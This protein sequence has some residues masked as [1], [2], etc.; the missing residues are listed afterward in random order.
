MVD[1]IFVYLF[2]WGEFTIC[3]VEFD[4]ARMREYIMKHSELDPIAVIGFVCIRNHEKRD[5][6]LNRLVEFFPKQKNVTNSVIEAAKQLDCTV[7][8]VSGD[9]LQRS[10]GVEDRNDRNVNRTGSGTIH[11]A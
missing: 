3:H 8:Y 10:L 1:G 4:S 9:D 7:V 11:A 5:S 6:V 2:Y